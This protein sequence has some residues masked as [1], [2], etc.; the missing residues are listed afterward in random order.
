MTSR[1]LTY[2][3]FATLL[4]ALSACVSGLNHLAAG[5]DVTVVH[6]VKYASGARQGMDVY[7]PTAGVAGGTSA[8]VGNTGSR[9][10]DDLPQAG[11][12]A[13]AHAGKGGVSAGLPVVVFL[14]GG[15]W[16]EGSKNDYA[17]VASSLAR[18][19]YLTFVPDYRV[20]PE[21]RYPDF[22]EDA[23]QAVAYVRRH[24]AQ[25]GGDPSRLVLVG[26]SAGAYLVAMLA[27]DPRWL[28]A[29]GLNP[30]RDI[31]AVVGLAGPY[32]FLPLHDP[33]LETIFT[34]PAG[35]PDTQPI[36]HVSGMGPPML[37]MAGRNDTLV[38]PGN[39]DRLA[40][41]IRARGGR[42]EEIMY[43]KASHRIIIGAFAPVLRFL[44]PSLADTTRFID[45]E[46]GR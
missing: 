35:L 4:P 32:D 11:V 40:A 19:G 22:I 23:A 36:N 39:T 16:Q 20:Y 17:F 45:R 24:A 14:Y 41:R 43:P 34:N 7:W 18:A 28:G 29:V 21:V 44:S 1:F 10:P 5:S 8:P 15:S 9:V 2:V 3:A 6:D 13:D 37:L 27:L 33:V 38:D 46:V 30:V 25:W 26:H 31:T 42:V 12:P